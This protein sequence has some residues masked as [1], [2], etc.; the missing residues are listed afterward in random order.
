MSELKPGNETTET[1]P[2]DK[3]DTALET[4]EKIHNFGAMADDVFFKCLTSLAYEYVMVEEL[5]IGLMLLNRCGGDYFKD[6]Q[7]KQMDED[8]KYRE[9]VIRLA[10]KLI[11]FG[12]VD[13]SELLTVATQAAAKA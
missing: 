9:L 3:I 7:P 8:E 10:Y 11:Q 12:V 13:G 4:V 1:R 6:V 5:D 2:R